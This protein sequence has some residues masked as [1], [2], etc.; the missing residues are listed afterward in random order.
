MGGTKERIGEEV[1]G[2]H[3]SS[4]SPIL[5]MSRIERKYCLISTSYLP[6][7]FYISISISDRIVY[8]DDFLP[9]RTLTMRNLDLISVRSRTY[10]SNTVFTQSGYLSNGCLAFSPPRSAS[11][12]ACC[13]CTRGYPS[14]SPVPYYAGEF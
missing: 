11:T 7:L 12:N 8:F 10:L 2:F 5:L 13:K 4:T 14:Q 6:R 3:P 1:P 9:M